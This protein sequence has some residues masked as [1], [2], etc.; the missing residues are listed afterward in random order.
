MFKS[1]SR[2][3][4]MHSSYAFILLYIIS[5]AIGKIKHDICIRAV[6]NEVYNFARDMQLPAKCLISSG[7]GRLVLGPGADFLRFRTSWGD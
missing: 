3:G 5:Y 6:M 4:T 1:E 7:Y 2:I